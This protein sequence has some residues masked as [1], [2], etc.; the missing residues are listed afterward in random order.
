M[1]LGSSRARSSAEVL[2]PSIGRTPSWASQL[3]PMRDT[4]YLALLASPAAA[5]G[6]VVIG[7]A[8]NPSWLLHPSVAIAR[9][10]AAL[11]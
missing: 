5:D 2:G 1:G 8:T 3:P 6:F 7:T 4:G 9:N 11:R 10:Y